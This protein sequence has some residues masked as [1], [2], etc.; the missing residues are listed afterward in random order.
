MINN[1]QLK[2]ARVSLFKH[3]LNNILK[4]VLDTQDTK[5]YQYKCYEYIVSINETCNQIYE[6]NETNENTEPK[7]INVRETTNNEGMSILELMRL[8]Q[9][10]ELEELLNKN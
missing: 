9:N 2:G 8:K 1:N 5:E 4:Y 3:K 6:T 7:I 10:E